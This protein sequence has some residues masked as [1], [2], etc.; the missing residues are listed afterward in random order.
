[1]DAIFTSPLFSD[2]GTPTANSEYRALIDNATA[3]VR[4][5]LI[6]SGQ[7][8]AE[9]RNLNLPKPTDEPAIAKQ[10]LEALIPM[11]QQR[12]SPQ[13]GLPGQY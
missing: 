12:A 11:L 8:E 1:M 4:K 10:K 9:L 7:S 3:Y 6:G 5:A 13:Y 2:V